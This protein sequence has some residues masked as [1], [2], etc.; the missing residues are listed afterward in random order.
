MASLFDVMAMLRMANPGQDQLAHCYFQKA[1]GKCEKPKC[2]LFHTGIDC[3][4]FVRTGECD[5]KDCKLAH[6]KERREYYANQAP[7][8]KD[9][10]EEPMPRRAAAL[11]PGMVFSVSESG[12]VVDE[13]KGGFDHCPLQKKLGACPVMSKCDYYHKGLDCAIFVQTSACVDKECKREHDLKR[14]ERYR[15]ANDKFF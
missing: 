3:E 8:F 2:W 6:E 5:T 9:K 10:E 13:N 4:A 12:Q 14:R 11:P 15:K 1:A 7:K